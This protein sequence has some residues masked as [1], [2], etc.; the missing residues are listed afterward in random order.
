MD[1][2][3][4][5]QINRNIGNC[6]NAALDCMITIIKF[7]VITILILGS[8]AAFLLYLKQYPEEGLRLYDTF[9]PIL[10]ILINILRV[11]VG[12]ALGILIGW[13]PFN[14]LEPILSKSRIKRKQR[15]EDFLD[16][17]SDKLKKKLKKK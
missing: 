12:F 14:I 9:I 17:L 13:L 7:I 10:E 15:R 8:T 16:E 2:K 5:K 1:K 11:I 4:K 3:Q 6:F